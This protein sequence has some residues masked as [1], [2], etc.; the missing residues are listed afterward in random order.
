VD[1]RR[2]PNI[3]SKVLNPAS[4]LLPSQ[5]MK[6][7]ILRFSSIGDIVLTTPVVR[8][9]K[10]KY[11]DAEIHYATKKAFHA[12][13]KHNPYINKIHLLD[14][15]VF[16]LIN[17][18]KQEKFDYVI[19]LHHNQRTWLIK[20]LLS[21][22]SFSF[23]KLNFEKWLMVNFKINR[24]PQQHIVDRY[25]ATCKQLDVINDGQGL[26]Y[27]IGNED[28]I[29]IASLPPAF[30]NGYIGWVIGAKQN[31]KQ[32]PVEKIIRSINSIH[33]PVVLMGGKEDAASAGAIIS[34][35]G[36]KVI[37]NACGKYS[38]NQS[39]SLVKQAKLI[40]TN[41]TGLMHIAAA[42][43]KTVFSIWGNTIPQFG[44]S[45]YYGN[46]NEDGPSKKFETLHLDCRPCSKLGYSKCPKGHFKCMNLIEE[47]KIAS[48]VNNPLAPT[49]Q[50]STFQKS[51]L[52][53]G[54]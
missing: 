10:K 11:P 24:L 30:H 19:D 37:Y 22:K 38:L 33:L 25:L 17:E 43:K 42:F 2:Q 21:V 5:H 23:N 48:E 51:N 36:N 35:A 45:P 14:D 53:S 3:L 13:L 4:F 9:L 54:A 15:S 34:A 31:T 29:D 18:L 7:L 28:E 6:F 32:F 40:I 46:A 52:I 47:V 8:C 44:M 12:I 39:A 27:F 20:T 1:N 26:D 49:S 50:S 41:D 16:T